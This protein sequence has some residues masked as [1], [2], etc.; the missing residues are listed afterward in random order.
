MRNFH[1]AGRSTVH[2]AHGM[3]ACE[4]PLAALA[5]IDMLRRGGTAADG[6]I[7]AAAVLAVVE[8]MATGIGGDAFCLVA[9]KGSA[10]IEGYN[11]SGRA[12]K[13]LSLGH[14]AGQ[15][16][17][18]IP[19]DSPHAVTIPGAVDCW[20]ALLARHGRLSPA[21]VLEPAIAYARD[22][23]AVTPR[24]S[25]EWEIARA[26]LGRNAHASA[27]WLAGGAVPRPGM[28][29]RHPAL[30]R[31][32]A[33]IAA[34]GRDGFYRGWVAE[35]M[36]NSLRALGGT[37]DLA[38]FAGHAGNWVEPVRSTYRGVEV[39]EIPPNG[40]GVTTL[41]MLNI[42]E[43]FALGD[44]PPLSAARFHVEAEAARLAFIE[45]GRWIADPD[46]VESSTA[47]FTDKAFAKSLAANIDPARAAT[48]APAMRTGDTTYLAVADAEG[49][50]VSFINSIYH[51]WGSG[52]ASDKSGVMFHD[53]GHGFLLDER[54]PN[55]LRG[56]KRPFHTIIPALALKTGKPWLAF[57]VMGGDFQPV[58]QTHVLTNIVDYA[59]DPQEAIDCPRAFLFEGVLN[60]EDGV[61][62]E[63]R[64]RLA[65]MGHAVKSAPEPLGGSQM[66]MRDFTGGT[67]IGGS[68]PR[69]DGCALG[70]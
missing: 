49:T 67:W 61:P 52:I 23:F 12:P 33:E 16:L 19:Q 43:N 66:V 51:G 3:A 18:R 32:L 68:D 26:K 2:A 7:A 27:H 63:T 31:A 55:A 60:V 39:C 13:A 35:D 46:H 30:A 10:A 14:F 6:A 4:H 29:F 15:N 47:H 25:Y 17:A 11:G 59:M 21:T 65:A 58:G 34:H 45:R 36:V 20:L 28:M 53:R 69:K 56:G 8:P 50:M 62:A 54:H 44:M 40:Q 9:S 37:H 48:A 64:E 41:L 22:G 57:G 24:I 70:Y 5:A 42:L 1:L 38:D